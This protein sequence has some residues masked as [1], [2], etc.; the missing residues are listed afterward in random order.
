MNHTPTP[1]RVSVTTLICQ[2][3]PDNNVGPDIAQ[4]C[5]AWPMKYETA[6]GNA[7]RIVACVNACE[8]ISTEALSSFGVGG[9][10]AFQNSLGTANAD[11]GRANISLTAALG[12]A[13]S[14]R[15]EAL[16]TVA[17]AEHDHTT[18][19]NGLDVLLQAE[20]LRAA[21]H[22]LTHR[23]VNGIRASDD[24][25][26][27]AQFALSEPRVLPIDDDTGAA[28]VLPHFLILGNKAFWLDRE[29]S[30]NFGP[31]L[32]SAPVSGVSVVWE[33]ESEEDRYSSPA[34]Y[35]AIVS[36]L[37]ATS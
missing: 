8:G 10:L 12:E 31:L 9:V 16:R 34:E 33:D 17:A 21:L 30:H 18:G 19:S 1:W 15:D 6:E 14:D 22:T 20:R 32:M 5:T 25:I 28:L 37:E 29:S 24:D 4:A 27:A 13:R 26:M 2:A 36:C 7:A 11:L 35:A 3:L 23:A